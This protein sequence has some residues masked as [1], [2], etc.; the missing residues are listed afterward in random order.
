MKKS[1]IVYRKRAVQ[2]PLDKKPRAAAL[3]EIGRLVQ[4]RRHA[5]ALER[6]DRE[7]TAAGTDRL[8]QARLL[9]QVADSEFKRGSFGEAARIFTTAG[10]RAMA[11]HQLWLRPLVGQV[12]ALLRDGQVE[13]ALMMARH[14]CQVAQHKEDSFARQVA[15]ANQTLRELGR[16]QAGP[17]PP[18][19]GVV[20]SRM[21][22]LFLNEGE[23]A[24]AAEFFNLAVEAHPKGACRAYQGLARIALAEGRAHQACTLATQ[25]IRNGSYSSKTLGAWGILVAARRAAGGWQISQNLVEGLARARSSV[26]ARTVVLLTRELRRCD[27]RQWRTVALAWLATESAAFPVEAAELRK[28]LVASAVSEAQPAAQRLESARALLQVPHLS[29]LE[30]LAASKVLVRALTELPREVPLDHLLVEGRQR[31]G[32]TFAGRTCHGLA[33]ALVAAGQDDRAAL[34]Y[35]QAGD[36]QPV[37]S[38]GWGRAVWALARLEARRGRPAEAAAWYERY[39]ASL[40]SPERFRIQAR[41]ER[42]KCLVRAGGA[43]PDA[44]WKRELGAELTAMDQP[45]IILD[46]ARLLRTVDPDLARQALELGERVT[47]ERLKTALHPALRLHLLFQLTRRQ[48]GDFGRGAA[49]LRQWER[50]SPSDRNQLW[51][52]KEQ[53]WEYLAYLLEACWQADRDQEGETWARHLLADPATPPV[54]RVQVLMS[55]GNWLVNRPGRAGDALRA[56]REAVALMPG[57][58]RCPVA[59]LWLA[60]LA[61]QRGDPAAVAGHTRLV[62]AAVGDQPGL[63]LDRIVLAKLALLEAGLEVDAVQA[64]G[65]DRTYLPEYREELVEDFAL[66]EG[67][68]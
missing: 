47:A 22:R 1:G 55:Y 13:E 35:R 44:G 68:V 63:R 42:I 46:T 2:K 51:S 60:M 32:E 48:V 21:G 7:L 56:F 5:R 54:G 25:S 27:M 30:W 26:R 4:R 24:A 36:L 34:L 18:R 14:A 38:T 17:R 58:A 6:I 33:Q 64:A 28:M 37:G 15:T 29:A 31:Y 40:N 8:V 67:E 9:S 39:A 65:V 45:E 50:L 20:A 10:V 61:Y 49:A 12:R 23:L 16:L 3:R 66:L 59:H 11:H 19:F 57:H 53:Y 62:R 41:L 52:E 43:A